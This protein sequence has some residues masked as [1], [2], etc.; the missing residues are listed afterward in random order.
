MCCS[1]TSR[2]GLEGTVGAIRNAGG[3]AMWALHDIAEANEAAAA[4]KETRDAF[5]RLDILVNNAGIARDALLVRMRPEDWH[6]VLATN[7]TGAFYVTRAAMRPML[8]ARFGRIITISSVVGLV[9][10]AGQANYAAAKGGL[11]AFTKSVAREGASRGITANAVAPGYIETAMTEAM[12]EEARSA[13]C[14]RIP[15]GRP[16]CPEDVAH[17]VLFLADE[18]SAYI[19]GQVVCV[20]GGLTA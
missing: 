5:G 8:R 3:E 1:R 9:G 20:D 19:T 15:L 11:V 7:L 2:V 14:E 10:N 12:H 17:A 13:W 16:G 6:A 18:G 4:V